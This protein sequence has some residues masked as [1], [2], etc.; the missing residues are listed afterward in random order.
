MK[1]Y[2]VNPRRSL[3]TLTLQRLANQKPGGSTHNAPASGHMTSSSSSGLP[4][5]ASVV[6]NGIGMVNVLL[7]SVVTVCKSD[8]VTAVLTCLMRFL[9]V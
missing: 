7:L 6:E 4:S 3:P 1:R 9:L 2:L 5:L 8:N